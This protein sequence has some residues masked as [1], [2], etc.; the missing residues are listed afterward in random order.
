LLIAAGVDIDRIARELTGA[1][2]SGLPLARS[3]ALGECNP[4][5]YEPTLRTV[6]ECEDG[7]TA[8]AVL[9]GNVLVD[10]E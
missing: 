7:G 9:H 1:L 2:R 8:A 6:R 5:A 10:V 3:R 4:N